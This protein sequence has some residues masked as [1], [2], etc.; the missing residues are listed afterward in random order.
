LADNQNSCIHNVKG[1]TTLNHC[2]VWGNSS[3]QIDSSA[4]VSYSNIQGG[5]PG[6]GNVDVD[7]YFVDPGYWAD[8]NNPNLL[9]EPDDPNAVWIDG[10]YH[11]QSQAGHW[12]QESQTWV[13]DDVNSPCIDAGDPRSDWTA[14]LLPNGELINMGA[15]GGTPQ[16]SMSLSTVDDYQ[17]LSYI[18][19][20][21]SF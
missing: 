20:K 14:E 17:L 13:Q 4:N 7:P 19:Q 8:L 1:I 15:Y 18:S 6:E 11:L 10:D 2:I 12:D 9:V 21:Q 16:A 5:F 3:D